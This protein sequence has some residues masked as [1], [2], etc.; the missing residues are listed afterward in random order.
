MKVI[1]STSAQQA[2]NSGLSL[3][4]FACVE[5]RLCLLLVGGY[6]RPSYMLDLYYSRQ[7]GRM[8]M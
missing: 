5:G 2:A 7:S 3:D 4:R 1:F 6:P 8:F